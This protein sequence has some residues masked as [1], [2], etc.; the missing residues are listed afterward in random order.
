MLSSLLLFAFLALLMTFQYSYAVVPL[1]AGGVAFCGLL[2]ARHSVRLGRGDVL[3]LA[4]LLL[5]SLL[6]LADVGRTGKWPVGEGNQGILLPLWPMLAALVLMAWRGLPPKTGYWWFGVALGALLAGGI[7]SYE[8]WVLGRGRPDNGMNAIPFGNISLLLATLSLV[9]LLAR[10]GMRPVKGEW[11]LR[12]YALAVG[13]G[14]LAAV[15]SGTRGSWIVFPA[16]I[17]LVFG[18]FWRQLHRGGMVALALLVAVVVLSTSFMPRA[19][20]TQRVAQAVENLEE[21]AEGDTYSSL[22]VRLEMWRAGARLFREKPILGWGEGRLEERRDQWVAEG[23]YDKGISRYDQLH[24]DLVDTAARRGLVG[25]ISLLLLYGVPLVLFATHLRRRRDVQGQALALS[26]VIVVVAF[27]GFGLTQ[28]LL[29]DVRG[30]SG[31]L[32]M[33]TACWCL[34][35]ATPEGGG[36][37]ARA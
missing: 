22:G 11:W 26:G 31:F 20:V 37:G 9:G 8:H 34:L 28:S 35:K 7:A 5:F 27:I 24:N 16:L 30:L 29:R 10:L 14:L 36:E 18:V 23:L 33:L 6:W 17:L 4:A 32:G 21:Y 13:A 15:L 12:G 19:G 2:F 25:L 1:L 3:C